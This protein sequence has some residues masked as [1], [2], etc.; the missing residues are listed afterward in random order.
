M[1]PLALALLLAACQ[2]QGAGDDYSLPPGDDV[3]GGCQQD[4]ECGAGDVCARTEEC[5][6][7]SAVRTVH[8]T[9]TVAGQPASDAACASV[10]AL[11]IE[12]YDTN[13][14]AHGYAPVP[15][16]AGRYTIDKL[17]TRFYRV[18][19]AL[20]DTDGGGR[21]DIDEQGNASLDLPY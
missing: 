18:R 5:L 7:A 21:A 2:P 17:P 12:F 15:C 16:A 14:L 4:G 6:P 19:L 1:R 11:E 13:E 10:G 20:V 3:Q 9:W 8:V